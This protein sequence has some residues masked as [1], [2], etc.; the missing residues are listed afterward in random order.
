MSTKDSLIQ[1]IMNQPEPLLR[2]VQHYLAFLLELEK[3]SNA[4]NGTVSTWPDGYF[5]ATAG[6][7]ENEPFERPAQLAFEKRQDW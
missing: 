6:A 2:E 3:R 7:F 5:E 4:P 1:E